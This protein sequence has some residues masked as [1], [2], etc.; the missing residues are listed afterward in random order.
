MPAKMTRSVP[1]AAV[2]AAR[3]LAAI[4]TSRGSCGKAGKAQGFHA[5]SGV[6]LGNP[7]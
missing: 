3:L 6:I 4:H 1:S 7:E 2:R 5:P